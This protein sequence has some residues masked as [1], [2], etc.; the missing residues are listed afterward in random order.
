MPRRNRLSQSRNYVFTIF[1]KQDGSSLPTWTE[2]PD[3]FTFMVW[4][5]ERCPRTHRLHVQGYCELVRPQDIVW[6]KNHL[7]EGHYET[8]KGTSSQAIA[9]CQKQESRVSPGGTLGV[10]SSGKGHRTDVE[11]FRDA[12]LS[13]KRKRD[14]IDSM[15]REICKWPRFYDL[16][17]EQIRPVRENKMC[18]IL[19]LGTT[20]TGKTRFAFDH[21]GVS[22]DFFDLPM[23]S[24]RVW[25][26]GLDGHTLILLDDFD[27]RFSKLSLSMLLRLLDRYPRRVEIKRNFTWWMPDIVYITT[28]INP[29]LWYNFHGREAQVQALRRRIHIILDFDALDNNG[30]PLDV[31]STHDWSNYLSID[32]NPNH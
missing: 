21:W 32:S 8:R 20:G 12:I 13:G 28:N 6:I 24:N 26:D 27:G 29:E 14:L 15:P 23:C 18:V 19:A 10:A 11:N 25:F 1:D 22:S 30:D 7:G 31:T 2:L 5:V 4:Q 17:R 9:Y 3:Q 16:I